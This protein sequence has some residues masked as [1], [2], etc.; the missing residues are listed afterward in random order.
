MKVRYIEM[1]R[2]FV[3]PRYPISGDSWPIILAYYRGKPV[4]RRSSAYNGIQGYRNV[5]PKGTEELLDPSAKSPTNGNS[6]V[7]GGLESE[8]MVCLTVL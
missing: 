4:Y 2:V 5:L 6:K 8:S 3:F 1:N 7:G